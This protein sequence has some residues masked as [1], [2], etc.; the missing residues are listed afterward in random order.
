M[1]VNVF[2]KN[3]GESLFKV[4]NVFNGSCKLLDKLYW[5]TKGELPPDS[6]FCCNFNA[7][8]NYIFD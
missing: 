4:R 3:T 2:V 1:K 6:T 7:I 8:Q 5:P